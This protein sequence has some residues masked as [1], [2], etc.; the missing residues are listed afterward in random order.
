MDSRPLQ[1][2]GK[3]SWFRTHPDRWRRLQNPGE[4]RNERIGKFVCQS[5]VH[6]EAL[7]FPLDGRATGFEDLLAEEK[8]AGDL[9][10]DVP[11]IKE[12]CALDLVGDAFNELKQRSELKDQFDRVSALVNRLGY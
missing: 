4:T 5:P 2:H 10:Y 6:I 8:A 12:V 11:P 3:R 7:P 1:C 9:N